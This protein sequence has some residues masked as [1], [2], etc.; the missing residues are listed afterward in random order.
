MASSI[1]TLWTGLIVFERLD[2][3][4]CWRANL[5]AESFIALDVPA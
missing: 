1:A 2:S 3:G 5:V 4:Q